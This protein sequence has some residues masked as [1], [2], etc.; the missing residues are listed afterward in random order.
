MYPRDQNILFML[1]F[2]VPFPPTYT[3]DHLFYSPG[4]SHK[5]LHLL[6]SSGVALMFSSALFTAFGLL[7][8]GIAF[9]R[10][11]MRARL[12]PGPPG[13]FLL[14]NLRDMPHDKPHWLTYE[15]WAE[16][17]GDIVY[18]EVLGRSMVI[19]NSLAAVTELLE[20]RSASYSD[21]PPMPM[22]NDLM[23]WHW[24]MVHM[25]YSNWWRIHRK[26]FHQSFQSRAVPAYYPIQ[27]KATRT[28]LQQLSIN[29]TGF[30][31]HIRHHAGNVILNVVYGYELQSENDPYVHLAHEAMKGLNQ[32]VHPGSFFVD[33]LP[34]LRYLPS[35]FPG[36]GFKRKA[37]IWAKSSLALRDIPFENLKTSIAAGTAI[38]SFVADNLEKLRKQTPPADEEI[39]KNCAGIAYLAGSD[40]T[41]SLILVWVLAMTLNPEVQARARAEVDAVIGDRLPDFSDRE[42]SS[43]PY[44]QAM[45]QETMRWAPVT[46]LAIPH[47]NM[48]DDEY[49]GYHIPAG[50]TVIGNIHAI[51][52]DATM[53]PEPHEFKPERF[54]S[55][56]GEKSPLRPEAVAFGFGRRICPGRDLALNSAWIVIVSILKT[57]IIDKAVD[58]NGNYIVPKVEFSP[59][60]VSWVQSITLLYNNDNV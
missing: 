17:F 33:F 13:L 59:G 35:W 30:V 24:D 5:D 21:R 18:V 29:P 34:A 20:K 43:F 31:D 37:K 7:A 58:S 47:M 3:P 10:R 26:T 51:L 57:Y 2:S 60:T 6:T 41:V 23:G 50:T 56:D 40:T 28:L 36:A 53:F 14:G 12:P 27:M 15:A 19:L 46:P 48:V 49:N 22:A 55:Q 54:L 9:K 8:L 52:H 16:K 1:P 4:L 44:I 38:P 45:L 39:I 11:R 25:R 32:A 42:R